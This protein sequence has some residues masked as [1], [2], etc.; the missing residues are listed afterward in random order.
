MIS[1]CLVKFQSKEKNDCSV[2]AASHALSLSY[3]RAYGLLEL[4]G[5][6]PKRGV[7]GRIFEKLGLVQR[8]DLACMPFMQAM[9]SMQTGRFVVFVPGH[10]CAVIDG[11]IQD[12]RFDSHKHRVRMVYEVPL[13]NPDVLSR[14]PYLEKCTALDK[15]PDMRAINCR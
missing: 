13:D 1:Y 6:Q 2:H 11:R 12:I 7:P 3:E 8:P 14:Y 5:R 15:L 4:C 9:E 10:F